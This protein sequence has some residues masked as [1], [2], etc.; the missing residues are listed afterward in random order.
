MKNLILNIE[1]YFRDNW[2]NVLDKGIALLLSPLEIIEIF[3]LYYNSLNEPL[4]RDIIMFQ[5][6]DMKIHQITDTLTQ[7]KNSLSEYILSST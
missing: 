6:A 1:N 3:F 7:I 2:Q 5:L 4:S